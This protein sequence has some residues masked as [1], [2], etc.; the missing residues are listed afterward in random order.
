MP[1]ASPSAA[2]SETPASI[3]GSAVAEP[4]LP[5]LTRAQITSEDMTFARGGYIEADATLVFADGMTQSDGWSQ[6]TRMVNGE[7]V[8][9]NGAGCI[10]SLRSTGLQAPLVAEGDDRASTEALFQFLDPS[11]L[12]EYLLATTWLWG[13]TPASPRRASNS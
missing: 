2:S 13:R 7:S 4:E 6:R 8:Y 11:I 1:G 12:P 3:P 9:E 5:P 10:A